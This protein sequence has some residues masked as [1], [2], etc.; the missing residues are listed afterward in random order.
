MGVEERNVLVKALEAEKPSVRL[1]AVKELGKLKDQSLV[2]YFKKIIKHDTHSHVRR[3]AVSSLGRLRDPKS[4]S[5]LCSITNDSD[6]KVLIQVVRALLIFKDKS[7]VQ[8]KIHEL[9]G[10][11]NEMIQEILLKSLSEAPKKTIDLR[12]VSPDVL[13]NVIV[14]G[15]ALQTLQL[16]PD[17]SFHL[18]F[19]SPPYYNARDYTF[20]KSYNEYL[21]FLRT[22][23]RELARVTKEG[24]FFIINTSPIIV[25]RVSRQHASKRYPIPFDLHSIIVEEGWEY[26]DDIIWLKPEASVKNRVGGFMQ[27]R[28]PLGYKPNT[29]TEMLMVYRKKTPKLLDWNMRAYPNEIV[30]ASKVMGDYDSSNV[31]KIDPVYNKNHTAVCRE[32]MCRKIIQY[33]SYKGDLIYDPFAGSGTLGDTAQKMGRYFFMTENNDEYFSYMKQ[34]F[35]VQTPSLFHEETTPSCFSI[36]Q[37]KKY[38]KENI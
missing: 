30:E 28:K 25:P 26:I 7:L 8:K 14:S 22:I 5:F 35:S 37:F 20:Y 13:K 38:I 15:D 32:T 24:R 23:V 4:I 3:E 17:E 18:T 19:T 34:R 36:N 11:E 10:H 9:L 16:L 12:V 1:H 27:H 29:V 31:W 21:N 6:P 33:Y 2:K